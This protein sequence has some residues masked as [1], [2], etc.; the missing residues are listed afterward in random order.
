MKKVINIY[1]E[2]KQ[3]NRRPL[4]EDDVNEIRKHSVINIMESQHHMKQVRTNDCKFI[5]RIVF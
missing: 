3:V 2:G 5:K 4:T 1:Y